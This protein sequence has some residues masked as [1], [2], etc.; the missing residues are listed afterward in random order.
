MDLSY[1]RRKAVK[2][3]NDS[4]LFKAL[5]L[6]PARVVRTKVVVDAT[7]LSI[8]SEAPL[9]SVKVTPE[10][11]RWLRSPLPAPFFRLTA[12]GGILKRVMPRFRYLNETIEFRLDLRFP[13]AP[14][15][16]IHI[17]TPKRPLLFAS[18][19]ALTDQQVIQSAYRQLWLPLIRLHRIDGVPPSRFL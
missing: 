9:K 15:F 5:P 11:M 13:I 10:L 16:S 8:V 18:G 17:H 14:K 3:L 7:G 19:K 4:Q 12:S 1:L 6:L 2:E